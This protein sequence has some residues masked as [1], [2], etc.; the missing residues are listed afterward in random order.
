MTDKVKRVIYLDRAT[1]EVLACEAKMNY[2]T[3]QQELQRIVDHALQDIG[4]DG[5][6]TDEPPIDED[7][8]IETHAIPQD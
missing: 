1:D 5:E 2:R 6:C 4:L 3:P 7:R 8:L